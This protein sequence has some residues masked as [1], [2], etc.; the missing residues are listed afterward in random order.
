[1]MP[2]QE[3]A[4]SGRVDAPVL[5]PRREVQLQELLGNPSSVRLLRNANLQFA[6]VLED[7]CPQGRPVE[8]IELAGLWPSRRLAPAP[9]AGAPS[10]CSPSDP[11]FRHPD[12]GS[13][14]RDRTVRRSR[15]S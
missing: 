15:L 13:R 5:S 3:L 6:A 8:L 12:G 4:R 7:A 11:A 9:V 2:E 10:W 1:M 14:G